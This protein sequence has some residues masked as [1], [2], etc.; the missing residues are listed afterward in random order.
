MDRLSGMGIIVGAGVDVT[1]IARVRRLVGDHS[2]ALGRIFTPGERGFCDAV[3]GR[4]R[5]ARY[6]AAFAAKEAVMKALG[7]G[8]RADVEWSDI[9]TRTID[10]HGG[11]ALSGGIRREAERLGVA[12]VLVSASAAGESAVASAV[13]EGSAHG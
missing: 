3:R 8:W 13:A 4:R 11:I 9:D 1:P 5:D 10:A 7:T 2:A 6:A 12:R